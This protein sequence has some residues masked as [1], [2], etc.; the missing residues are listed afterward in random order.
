MLNYERIGIPAPA[1]IKMAT[2]NAAKNLGIDKE[3]GTV[4]VGKKAHLILVKGNPTKN[5]A[6]LYRVTRTIKGNLVIKTQELRAGMG[7]TPWN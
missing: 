6:D 4:A 5:I 3:V 7:I 2:I 1:I